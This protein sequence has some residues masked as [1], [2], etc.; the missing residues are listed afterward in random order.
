MDSKLPEID[1][2]EL[3]WPEGCPNADFGCELCA[4]L[5]ERDINSLGKSPSNTRKDQHD[6]TFSRLYASVF[7]I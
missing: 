2:H 6:E 5:D 1:Q 4:L 3:E 7:S